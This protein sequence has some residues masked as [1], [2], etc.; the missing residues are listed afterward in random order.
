MIEV[1]DEEEG[2]HVYGENADNQY[3]SDEENDLLKKLIENIGG[4]PAL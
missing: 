4:N 1:H 2:A 3:E